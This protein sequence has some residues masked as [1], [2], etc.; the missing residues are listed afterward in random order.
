MVSQ[1]MKEFILDFRLQVPPII[2]SFFQVM[3]SKNR[4]II[5]HKFYK[6]YEVTFI[7]TIYIFSVTSKRQVLFRQRLH[8]IK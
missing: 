7:A 5:A 3:F 6:F 1:G 4:I 2:I 8:D